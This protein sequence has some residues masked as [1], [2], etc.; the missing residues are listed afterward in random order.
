M[1]IVQI[2]QIIRTEPLQIFDLLKPSQEIRL[3]VKNSGMLTK[4]DQFLKCRVNGN[5]YS[6]YYI[7]PYVCLCKFPTVAL[8]SSQNSDFEISNDALTFSSKYSVSVATYLISAKW[9]I[10]SP[11]VFFSGYTINPVILTT[12][13]PIPAIKTL[14]IVF[15][16]NG[17][18]I[19]IN[20]LGNTISG[21]YSANCYGLILPSIISEYKV[22]A[23]I[24][25]DFTQPIDTKIR[26]LPKVAPIISRISP[27]L[28]THD[29]IGEAKI[30][31][32]EQNTDLDKNIQCVYTNSYYYQYLRPATFKQNSI[33]CPIEITDTKSDVKYL[34][35]TLLIDQYYTCTELRADANRIN[36]MNPLDILEINPNAIYDTTLGSDPQI[37]LNFKNSF[38]FNNN[39]ICSFTDTSSKLSYNGHAELILNG[40]SAICTAPKIE[41]GSYEISIKDS[42]NSVI[43]LSNKIPVMVYAKPRFGEIT[44]KLGRPGSIMQIQCISGIQSS[45]LLY[46]ISFGDVNVPATY[47]SSENV[48]E[49]TVPELNYTSEKVITVKV[50]DSLEYTHVPEQGNF[51]TYF[52]SIQF[53]Y[54]TPTKITLDQYNSEILI[55]KCTHQS[56][57]I[58]L[59]TIDLKCKFSNLGTTNA[60]FA[61]S[62]IR[63]NLLNIPNA[64]SYSVSLLVGTVSE[65]YIGDINYFENYEQTS[66]TPNTII[67][68]WIQPILVTGNKFTKEITCILVY[69]NGQKETRPGRYISQTQVE[70]PM[71]TYKIKG[72]NF[73]LL[74]SVDGIHTPKFSVGKT[75]DQAALVSV[76]KRPII[77]Q[78][79]IDLLKTPL[80]PATLLINGAN[81]ESINLSGAQ[82]TCIFQRSYFSTVTVTI[83]KQISCVVPAEIYT[84]SEGKIQVF[85]RINGL[86]EYIEPNGFINLLP[87]PVLTNIDP[88]IF[89]ANGNIELRLSLENVNSKILEN[90]EQFNLI[91]ESFETSPSLLTRIKNNEFKA[92]TNIYAISE[93]SVTKQAKIKATLGGSEVY[94]NP[95]NVI[96]YKSIEISEISTKEI[97]GVGK[98]TINVKLSANSQIILTAKFTC[99]LTNTADSKITVFT[100]NIIYNTDSLDCVFE[101]FIRSGTYYLQ[102]SYN[103]YQFSAV[104][105]DITVKVLDI[106][107]ISYFANLS[108][109]TDPLLKS[110]D[111]YGSNLNT[112][113]FW[114][115]FAYYQASKNTDTNI[116]L[117]QSSGTVT[118]NKLHCEFTDFLLYYQ[119]YFL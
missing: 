88:V 69:S 86:Q 100:Q 30:E 13:E 42:T 93:L 63:C 53:G 107:T 94:T 111:I 102:I 108:G 92:I 77:P 83:A 55:I 32:T 6:A 19:S 52:E 3:F 96:I 56:C 39:V 18:S 67:E 10:Q 105:N 115:Y 20:C 46:S 70:C 65:F 41:A 78:F 43:D 16:T 7:S 35:I 112:R 24:D 85:L 62:E 118:K 59:K 49:F 44:P 54:F 11:T 38:D 109:I 15:D 76:L 80:T 36:L 91:I 116:K 104:N 113:S 14:S 68:G 28:F 117:I 106:P 81:I 82:A 84:I 72:A 21:V 45:D 47:K 37:V 1:N 73:H 9:Q 40:K 110:I 2:P 90:S 25:Q 58:L 57:N 101:Q 71:G 98:N 33:Y 103:A 5:I 75:A 61:Q 89:N 34:D 95:V 79:S 87:T 119:T 50:V 17:T 31:F 22:Y 64:G 8:A 66:V 99:K 51:F 23:I 27:A 60:I 97:I 114:C 74:V 48:L 26:I 12:K 4:S 29:T